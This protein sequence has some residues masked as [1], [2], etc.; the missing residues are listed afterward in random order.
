MKKLIKR[1]LIK[2][3]YY[4][5]M[6]IN[7]LVYTFFPEYR[8]RPMIKVCKEYFKNKK[9]NGAEIGVNQGFNAYNIFQNLNINKMYLID[10]WDYNVDDGNGIF[11]DRSKNFH[12]SKK[13][14]KR[15]NNNIIWLKKY[16]N[17]AV[18]DIKENLDFIYIDGNHSFK[19]VT[20]DI[21]NYFPL[22]KK[23][24]IIGGHDFSTG[25]MGVVDAVKKFCDINNLKLNF[26]RPDWWIV[27]K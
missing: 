8:T 9:V 21:N 10:C 6:S 22:V 20:E 26:E 2:I 5:Q 16:S 3:I 25:W 18:K 19:S 27:K 17:D 12:V 15:F 13:R 4:E 11:I 24:G 1:I 14:L 7:T 23:G